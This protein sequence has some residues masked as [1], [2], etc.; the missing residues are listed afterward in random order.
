MFESET[1]DDM[2]EDGQTWGGGLLALEKRFL[3]PRQ[4]MIWEKMGSCVLH[5]PNTMLSLL[6]SLIILSW[7]GSFQALKTQGFERSEKYLR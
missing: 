7:I 2:G 3:S 4:L 6:R 5:L 1:V